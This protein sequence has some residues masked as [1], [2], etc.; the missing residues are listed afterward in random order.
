MYEALGL[1]IEMN[2]GAEADVKKA[3]NY[4][5]DLAQKTHNPNHLIS[6]A[7]RLFLEGYLERV[8]PLL[9]EA[10]PK[11]PHRIEPIVM[12]INLAQK[13]K[14]PVQNGRL[15]RSPASR[16]AGPAGTSI[17]ASRREHQ[18][19]K[20]VKQ[21][22]AE[23]KVAEAD[24]L[25]KKLEESSVTR[26]VRPAD[27]GRLRRFRPLGRRAVRSDARITTC[28]EPSSEGPLI[29]NGYGTHPEEIYVC[30]RGFSG[31][32]TIRVA[33]IWSD[34]KRPVTKLTLEV[35]THEGTAREQKLTRNLKP[36]ANNPPTEV[37]LTDGRRKLALPFV[38]P[39]ATVMESAIE[40][41]KENQHAD[42]SK[43]QAAKHGNGK[44][45][46]PGPTRKKHPD[47]GR[48]FGRE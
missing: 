32:Y 30:P 1:A 35:I 48:D 37:T 43:Q 27:L 28:R 17:S 21:L 16:S 12:S 24:L 18:V 40:A 45:A 10:M 11:V 25:Q 20:M 5:A 23:N 8:G 38:D 29:K 4:A 41:I 2:E 46:A 42:K 14:D 19:D 33:N 26:R 47:D 31:K 15:G 34:P 7:D 22:R 3:F 6:V 9:D 44:K 39:S 36:D 13:T